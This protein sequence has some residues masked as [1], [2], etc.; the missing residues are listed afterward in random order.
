MKIVT[1]Q[2]WCVMCMKNR[3][4][5]VTIFGQKKHKK[6]NS[7]QCSISSEKIDTVAEINKYLYDK[8]MRSQ[9]E[10]NNT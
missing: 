7:C 1:E 4:I 10:K 2:G 6:C 3:T 9:D 5:N 8:Y